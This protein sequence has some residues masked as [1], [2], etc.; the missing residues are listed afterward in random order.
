MICVLFIG[1]Y[2]SLHLGTIKL[3]MSTAY[4]VLLECFE[5]NKKEHEQLN[6]IEENKS[7][8]KIQNNNVSDIHKAIIKKIR[9]PRILAAIL[10][11]AALAVSGAAYQSMFVNPLVSPSLLGVLAGAAFG[12]SLGMIISQN[13]FITQVFAV[14][15]GIVAVLFSLF[16]SKYFP[17]NRLIMMIMG[18]VISSTLFTSLLSI[19]KYIADA[20]NQLPAIV[21][22]LMGGFS[23]VTQDTIN[24]CTP[25]LVLCILVIILSSSYLNVLSIG[26]EEALSLGINVQYVRT[27][28]I[29]ITTLCSSVTVAVGGMIGWVGMMIPH[30]ARMIVGHDN[31]QMVLFSGLLGALYLMIID[32]I[33]RTLLATEIPIGIVTSIIGVP[34]FI[35]TVIKSNNRW[36]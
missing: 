13:Y 26:D 28:L 32:T 25:V 16:L 15:F 23:S 6:V 29:I 24:F 1:A 3:P 4:N 8:V 18:G 33:C 19:V 12:A 5:K 27:T 17:G 21:Y 9:F 11:G 30:I 22:W 14:I 20:K 2:I 10:C 35:F 34:F 31:R 7:D 36:N